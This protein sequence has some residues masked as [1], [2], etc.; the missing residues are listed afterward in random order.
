MNHD[1]SE[2]E[3]SVRHWTDDVK[4]FTLASRLTIFGQLIFEGSNS[5]TELKEKALAKMLEEL[6]KP[7]DMAMDR[8]HNWICDQEDED[9]FQGILKE[10]YSLK[11]ALK[12]AKEKARKFAENGVACIDDNT[13]FGWI[14]EYFVSNSQVSNIKQVPVEDIKK[15]V[16]KPKNH[17]EDKVDVAKI[18]EGASPDDNIIKK[19]NI[20]KEK[21]V[22]EGQLDLFADLA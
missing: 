19:P 1:K 2:L 3:I 15:K 4:N 12:Y 14:R 9:L 5:M 18:R 8:I 13:V 11:C 17:P 20:K 10:R 22:V 21:G 6:N 16:E 7:H